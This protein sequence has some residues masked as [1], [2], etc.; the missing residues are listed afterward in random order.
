MCFRKGRT[1]FCSHFLFQ[2]CLALPLMSYSLANFLSVCLS[3]CWLEQKI[4]S[5]NSPGISAVQFK[6]LFLFFFSFFLWFRTTSPLSP[7]T[8]TR[9]QSWT[10]LTVTILYSIFISVELI[11]NKVLFGCFVERLPKRLRLAAF[12]EPFSGLKESQCSF[13]PSL[14]QST[15]LSLCWRRASS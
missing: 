11:R 9:L 12:L 7:H 3:V 2:P 4:T 8:Y 14:S 13:Y 10:F 1:I 15:R 6:G 5:L